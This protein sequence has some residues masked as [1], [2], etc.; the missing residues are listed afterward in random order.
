[1][2]MMLQGILNMPLPDDPA[3]LDAMTWLQIKDRMREA[4]SE[5]GRLQSLLKSHGI[6]AESEYICSCGLR[7]EPKRSEPDF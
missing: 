5:L 3:E 1:M 6:N 7:R 2:G 4:A